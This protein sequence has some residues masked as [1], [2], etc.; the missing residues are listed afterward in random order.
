MTPADAYPTW[1]FYPPPSAPP[2]WVQDVLD[3]VRTAKAQIDSRAVEHLTSDI[4]LSFLR[5]GLVSLGFQVEMGKQ[6]SQKIRRPVLFGRNGGER[7]AF[8][9]DAVHDDFGI[10]VEIEAGRGAR[11]NAVYRD[12]IRSSLV[13]G[14]RFLVLGV[15]SEYRHQSS[16]RA[17]TV[18]SFR[19]A[20]A[21]LDAVYASGRLRLPFDGVLLFGY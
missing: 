18:D 12:L 17:I 7:V 9:V 2:G 6:K 8:E 11:G 14:A 16:G 10:L 15:M 21:L 19:E 20:E 1:V 3:V 5:P 13:I 4:V